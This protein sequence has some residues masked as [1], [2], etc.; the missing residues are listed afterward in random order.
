[1]KHIRRSFCLRIA[2]DTRDLQ[3]AKTGSGTYLEEVCSALPQVSLEH[4][5]IF[6]QPSRR[7]AHGKSI[8][9]KI[10]NHF[11]FYWWKEVG[12]P[13][14]AYRKKCDVIFCTDYVVP[15]YASCATVPVFHDASFWERTDNYNRYW[16]KLLNMIGVPAA[17]KSLA[18][19]TVSE[20][21]KRRI[22]ESTGIPI[23]KME[24]VYEAPKEKIT[25]PLSAK[26]RARILEEYSL[27]STEPFILHVGVMEKR[28]N[29][30]RLVSAFALAA[31]RLVPGCKLVLVGQAGPK[32]DM[33]DSSNV[34]RVIE[35]NQ[36]QDCVVLTG[37]VPDDKLGAFYQSALMYAF[38]SLYEGFGLPILEAFAS[39]LPVMAANSTSL[40]EVAGDAALFFNPLDVTDMANVM[41]RI[42]NEDLLRNELVKK[43][44]IRLNEFSW[45][46]TAVQL[47]NIFERAKK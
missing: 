2:I 14:Q 28:K 41:M 30:S 27:S 37:Y 13:W 15:Y 8:M 43:G 47:I 36:L 22:A 24:V 39:D 21:A 42:A 26:E 12:L 34:L 46:K 35:E 45:T 11:R 19:V 5:I 1:M 6:L 29:L 20:S 10:M 7:V 32:Q 4:E 38:P 17:R 33:D 16:L 25:T 18:M 3:L 44:R 31:P 40:P 9:D 23:E